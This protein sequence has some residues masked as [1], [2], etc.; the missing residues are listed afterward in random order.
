RS[1]AADAGRNRIRKPQKIRLQHRAESRPVLFSR[2]SGPRLMARFTDEGSLMTTV[3]PYRSRKSWL[4]LFD[5][6]LILAVLSGVAWGQ[7]SRQGSSSPVPQIA[8]A[9]NQEI[10]LL[11]PGKPLEK[12]IS[13]GQ[14]HSYQVRLAQGEYVTVIVDQRGVDLVVKCVDAD[15][16]LI[17]EF[18]SENRTTGEERA[19]LAARE[20]GSYR[21]DVEPKYKT[22]PGGRYQ[23][24]VGEL[25]VSTETDRQ[26]QEARE[27]Y[28]KTYY[29]IVAGKYDEA[30]TA[31][32]SALEIRQKTI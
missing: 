3:L 6:T 13:G 8:A 11:E 10:T 5:A 17:A 28:T 7:A 4:R 31:G 15:G 16:K 29:A 2:P 14:K 19:E 9:A 25:R 26:L 24:R 22:L 12:E 20:A 18:D 30:Q 32:E 1:R 27:L 21:F 23:V